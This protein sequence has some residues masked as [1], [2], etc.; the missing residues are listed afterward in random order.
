MMTVIHERMF[1]I[2]LFLF[3]INSYFKLLTSLS[4]QN[5]LFKKSVVFSAMGTSFFMVP[6]RKQNLFIFIWKKVEGSLEENTM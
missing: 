5:A 3:R 2:H 6:I 1:W 4:K